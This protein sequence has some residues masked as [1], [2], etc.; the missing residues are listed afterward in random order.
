MV[1]FNHKGDDKCETSQRNSHN[2]FI[3]GNSYGGAI[4]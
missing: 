4:N 1:R 3:Y 2:A